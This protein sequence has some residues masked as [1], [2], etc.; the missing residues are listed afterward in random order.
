M[1]ADVIRAIQAAR[2]RAVVHHPARARAYAETR[3]IEADRRSGPGE[4]QGDIR[5]TGDVIVRVYIGLAGVVDLALDTLRRL[6]PVLSGAYRDA[7]MVLVG[8]EP[9]SWPVPVRQDAIITIVNM[10]PYARRIEGPHGAPGLS[11][12]A[13]DGVYEVAAGIV[14]ARAPLGV[15]IE[16]NYRG[17]VD[18]RPAPSAIENVSQ[19][20]FP[21]L[22]IRRARR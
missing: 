11:D 6:S 20:R 2:I 8:Q 7:H 19:Y 14:A 15:E 16:F 13:P 9:V 17:M 1:A 18:G 4:T 5:Q 10:R 22:I 21:A 12:Q 3:L